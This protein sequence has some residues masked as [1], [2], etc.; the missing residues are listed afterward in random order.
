MICRSLALGT[1]LSVLAPTSPSL[2]G[3]EGAAPR[4]A[5]RLVVGS[6]SMTFQGQKTNWKE[7]PGLLKRVPDRGQTIL[8]IAAAA[9]ELGPDT[10]KE[11]LPR[12]GRLA[13]GL[14]FA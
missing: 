14:G 5:V 2:R 4:Y 10:E 13:H 7:L 12:A 3:D 8:T 6:D 11:A 1:F 9:R